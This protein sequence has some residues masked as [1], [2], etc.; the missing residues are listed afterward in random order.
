M[1]KPDPKAYAIKTS[2]LTLLFKW[3]ARF[4]SYSI[5]SKARP[6]E[7]D[8]SFGRTWKPLLV[9]NFVMGFLVIS[10]P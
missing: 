10:G 6:Q 8:L 9:V 2:Q 7:T 5:Y 3:A 1:P 4:F